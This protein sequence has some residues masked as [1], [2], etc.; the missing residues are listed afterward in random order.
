M[1]VLPGHCS[2]TYSGARMALKTQVMSRIRL[3]FRWLVRQ[4]DLAAVD[5][6][7]SDQ[8]K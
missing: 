6:A 8:A 7:V 2:I 4:G 5:K 3:I 1:I